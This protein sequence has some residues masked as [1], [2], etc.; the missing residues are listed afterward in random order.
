MPVIHIIMGRIGVLVTYPVPLLTAHHRI[1]EETA[2]VSLYL[3]IGQLGPAHFDDDLP[4][5]LCCDLSGI[6]AV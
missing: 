4:Q 2:C 3:G 1:H 6:Y 5:L